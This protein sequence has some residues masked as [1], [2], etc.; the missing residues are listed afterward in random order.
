MR[1]KVDLGADFHRLAGWNP[2]L[3]VGGYRVS[4]EIGAEALGDAAHLAGCPGQN[5]LPTEEVSRFAGVVRK[6]RGG[7]SDLQDLLH[8]GL[9]HETVAGDHAKE[10]VL[11]GQ[12]LN[13]L[14][15]R[16]DRYVLGEDR[17]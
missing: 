15:G 10:V 6:K 3:S 5:G 7:A 17:H 8:I 9:L 1:E 4:L 13:P 2:E 12:D 16:N 14:F 11:R